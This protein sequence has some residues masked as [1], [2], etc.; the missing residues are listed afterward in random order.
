MVTFFY[1]VTKSL[2]SCKLQREPVSHDDVPLVMLSD[3]TPDGVTLYSVTPIGE[4]SN[5]KIINK[6]NK[7]AK[8]KYTT[9]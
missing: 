5:I 2:S 4:Y 9:Y 7:N 8:I 1:T 3:V 6:G